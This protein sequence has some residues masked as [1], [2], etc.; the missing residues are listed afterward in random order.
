[1]KDE[2]EQARA[3]VYR[4]LAS[5]RHTRL[6]LELRLERKGFSSEVSLRILEL[7]TGY[8]Y[9]DDRAFARLWVEQ[10]KVKRGIHGLRQ[11]LLKKGVDKEDIA[12][13]LTEFGPDMEWEA[14]LALAEKK[15]ALCGG[16]C[17]LSRLAGFL[18]RRGFSNEVIGRVCRNFS[19]KWG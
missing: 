10:R 6:E 16:V 19:D 3:F 14:A 11:E 8:G 7:M 1:V 2:F 5:R 17:P 4:L 18:Q 15:I 13:I 12:E 9:I